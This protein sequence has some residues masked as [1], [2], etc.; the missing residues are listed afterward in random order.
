MSRPWNRELGWSLH[1]PKRHVSFFSRSCRAHGCDQQTDGH[2]DHATC[3]CSN[4]QYLAVVLRG[5]RRIL[6]R[7]SMS[8][9]RLRR[10]IFWKCDYETVH[11]EVYPNKYVVSIAPFS[12]S[13]CPDCSQ[14]ILKTAVF[15]ACFRF[16]FFH[17]FFSKGGGSADRI[18]PY[19]RTPMVVLRYGL[20]SVSSAQ[21]LGIYFTVLPL[22]PPTARYEP[23]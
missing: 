13:A 22:P 4:R 6:V 21:N 19:V 9:C 18:C 15:F 8:P 1:I 14:N 10:R 20:R 5:V 16:L 11:S 2:T 7:G 3:I 17:Q 23:V 12:T